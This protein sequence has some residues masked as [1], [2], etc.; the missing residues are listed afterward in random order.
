MIAPYVK[1]CLI[2]PKK[3][4]KGES[5]EAIKKMPLVAKF[6]PKEVEIRVRESHNSRFTIVDVYLQ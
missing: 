1:I 4:K 2:V 3:I 5:L 6:E